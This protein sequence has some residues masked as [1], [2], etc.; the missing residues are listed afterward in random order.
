MQ[1]F[2]T[3]N[4]DLDLPVFFPDATRAVV[5]SLD[6]KDIKLTKTPGIL[7]NTYHLYTELGKRVLKKFGGIRE[8]M[9]FKGGVI[10]DSGGFQIMSLCKRYKGKVTDEG[11][12]FNL[13]KKK[14]VKLT[15]EKSIQ[16]QMLLKPDMLVVLDDFTMP[17]AT[18]KQAKETVDRTVLWA[19]R[20]K[21]EFENICKQGEIENKPYLLAVIQGGK[22]QNLRKECAK[23]LLEIG[24]DGYGYGGWP[25][26]D[27]NSFD[28]D[29]AETISKMIPKKDHFLY[30]L[31]IGKPDE[32][33]NLVKMGFNIFDCVLPTRDAR[34]KRL[35]VYTA[36]SMD[37]IDVHQE[38]FY[39]YFSP[40]KQM[41]YHDIS[42]VST[43]CDCLLCTKYSRGYL[44]HLFK[45]G[46]MT[47]G[48][49]ATIHNLRFYAI[50]MKKLQK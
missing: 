24:F 9:N 39:K 50:L 23:R 8:F 11:V 16:Y 18:E 48:R 36:D 38:G 10:S 19:K 41:Y 5:R 20:C 49:L 17:G 31:G 12:Y 4:G 44:N 7:V 30:G 26:N 34:H 33:V 21:D 13:T 1:K 2:K 29:S 32:I 3:K 45:I 43:A 22:Y 28:Y 6:T 47:A 14:K 25:M 37:K 35:Y 40:H 15:P 46:D 27:D 42:P